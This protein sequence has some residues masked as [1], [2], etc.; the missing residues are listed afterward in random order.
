MYQK[1]KKRKS[2]VYYISDNN[3]EDLDILEKIDNIDLK[4]TKR[5]YNKYT[6]FMKFIS[7][8]GNLYF[9]AIYTALVFVLT[10]ILF[11]FQ[12][13]I[14]FNYLLSSFIFF[15]VGILPINM[16]I[17]RK[18]PYQREELIEELDIRRLDFGRTYSYS[19]P[20]GH[21]SL[22]VIQMTIISFI[23][24]QATLLITIP[25]LILMVFSR[26]SL[27]MHFLSD[28]I[29]GV[30]FGSIM[31]ILNILFGIIILSFFYIAIIFI[32]IV[33]IL[34]YNRRLRQ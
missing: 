23:F 34:Q 12:L 8:F 13:L 31:G 20:S 6:N 16:I 15:I 18:R 14:Y 4:V 21:V 9:W 30:I 17:T 29:A 25:M 24:G 10:L 2:T 5:Y 3:N 28:C 26:I 27:G 11:S 22:F 7:I 19:F 32:V 1:K 33:L